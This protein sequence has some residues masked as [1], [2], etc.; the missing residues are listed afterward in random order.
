MEVITKE[1]L[2]GK[3]TLITGP[4]FA[5]K[6]DKIIALAEQIESVEAFK[7]AIHTR[8]GETIRSR[9]G[10]EIPCHLV[11]DVA[12]IKNSQAQAVIIDEFQFI[13]VKQLKDILKYFK[14]ERK[15]LIIAGLRKKDRTEYWPNYKLI[16]EKKYILIKKLEARCEVCGEAAKYTYTNPEGT[17]RAIKRIAKFKT[18]REPRCG[19]CYDLILLE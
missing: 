17:K 12:E 6:S 5:G 16:K 14:K 10:R 11:S 2:D 7:P 15:T 3:I 1:E 18:A 8:D 13:D 19:Q 9:T 4:M